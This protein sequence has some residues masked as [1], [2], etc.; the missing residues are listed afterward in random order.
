MLKILTASEMKEVDRL[1][2]ERYCVPSLTLMENAARAVTGVIFERLG[3]GVQAK[4]IIVLCGKG[5]NGGDGAAVARMLSEAGAQ[6]NVLLFGV[7][8]ETSG[9]ARVNFET[10]LKLADG[11]SITEDATLVDLGSRLEDADVVVDALFGTGLSRP[12]TGV[13]AEA[14][15]AV[16]DARTNRTGA[17]PLFVA[18]DVPSGL[19]ADSP[20]P[21]GPHASAD[22]TV[23]FTSPKLANVM[24]PASVF[25]GD[26][27]VADIGSPR[28]LIEECGSNVFEAEV[29]DATE[30]LRKTAFT[31]D[32]YKNKRG[33]LLVVAGAGEYPGAAVLTANAA[34][35]S[36]VGLV[37]LVSPKSSREA[38]AARTVPEIIM[39]S[40]AETAEGAFSSEAFAEIDE[41]AASGADA[42]AIGSGITSS[43]GGV[44]TLVRRIVE[45]RRTPLVIDADGL[46]ALSPFDLKG[47]DEIPIVLTPHEGEF[48]RL[49]GI[50]KDEL[51]RDRVGSVRRFALESETVVVLKGQRN[52]VVAPDGR[53]VVVPTGNSGLGKAGSGD[54]LAG[55]IA[56]FVAQAVKFHIGVFETVVAAV[57]IA[58][59]AG[60]IAEQRWGKRVMLASD[61][62]EALSDAFR[63][64]SS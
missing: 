59:L 49:S 36:G 41:M 28:E 18:V 53:V 62:R 55:V 25:C 3:T 8:S 52:L 45:E 43:S 19:G 11:P 5:N 1:T 38:I 64:L 6:V 50:S 30:W 37:T 10:L 22:V 33:H 60:D 48:L 24:P 46:N 54:T 9:D 40:A 4:R 58:G 12:L 32:S 26:V 15:Q 17:R 42:I 35:M 29:H 2:V 23:T 31:D 20:A 14:V 21:I 47:S 7:V 61:V 63:L 13:H 51:A 27:I 44:R 57:Y 16:F 34:M 39:R 56:G